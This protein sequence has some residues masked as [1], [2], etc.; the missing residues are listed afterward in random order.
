[1]MWNFQITDN[2]EDI[3]SVEYQNKWIQLL[4]KS[5]NSHV[6]FHPSLIKA[7]VDTYRPIRDIVPIFIFGKSEINEVF[8]PLVLWKMNWKNAFIKTIV[9]AGYSDFDYHDPIFLHIPNSIEIDTF[10]DSI[11]K[12]L[13]KF[14]YDEFICDGMHDKF[15]NKNL[16]KVTNNNCPFLDL[17]SINN[18][19]A[20]LNFFSQSLRGDIRRQIRRLNELGNLNLYEYKTYDD[21]ITTIDIFL[22]EHSKRWP[23][24]YKAPSFHKNIILNGLNTTVHFSSLN[25]DNIPIAWH[26]GFEFCKTYYYYMPAGA[27]NYSRF[28]P[29]KI[30]LYHLIKRAIDLNYLKYDHLRGDETYKQGW[31]NGIDNVHTYLKRNNNFISKMKLN[32]RD[33]RHLISH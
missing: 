9:P 11:N 4:Q 8:F 18:S 21:A 16:S 17:T 24:A 20:L 10:W 22:N 15:C 19:T 7:W 5:E 30:H 6:F 27:E 2:W 25:I 32:I 1:M 12:I 3:W 14:N 33:I 28:S 31:S 23:N 26:L 29:V 13:N